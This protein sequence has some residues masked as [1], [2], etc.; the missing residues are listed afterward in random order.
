MNYGRELTTP[1]KLI[2]HDGIVYSV[3]RDFNHISRYRNLRQIVHAPD[4]VDRYVTLETPNPFV[5][6]TEV[7]YHEVTVPEINRL[8]IIAEKELGSST[9]AWV[10]AYFNNIEDGYTVMEGQRLKIPEGGITKLL[11]NGEILAP[12]TPT[13]LNLGE[14]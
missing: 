2:Q 8:D 4:S 3:C 6:H 9:Y 13:K 14:E 12:I 11:N 5:T 10:I 1:Y 7:K